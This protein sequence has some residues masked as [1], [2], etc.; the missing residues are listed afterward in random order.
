MRQRKKRKGDS[1]REGEIEKNITFA[2]LE[3]ERECIV[4]Q[5]NVANS[6]F[7]QKQGRFPHCLF[8]LRT[9]CVWGD[10]WRVPWHA[11]S[12]RAPHS[13]THSHTKLPQ[14]AYVS[15]YGETTNWKG[16]VR[17]SVSACMEVWKC[18]RVPVCGV[19]LSEKEEENGMI[20]PFFV[21]RNP[22]LLSLREHPGVMRDEPETAWLYEYPS[23][24]RPVRFLFLFIPLFLRASVF[25]FLRL[26]NTSVWLATVVSEL[27]SQ[28]I[29][30]LCQIRC[31]RLNASFF[32]P[33]LPFHLFV[34]KKLNACQTR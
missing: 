31:D 11:V 14:C 8:P 9:G 34:T 12:E 17:M 23:E 10:N 21:S 29:R 18:P 27:L 32:S 3:L 7:P 15:V 26:W 2:S 24:G 1:G 13:A 28:T 33:L 4:T 6:R 19:C 30:Q 5:L 22:F 25:P 16:S 20:I